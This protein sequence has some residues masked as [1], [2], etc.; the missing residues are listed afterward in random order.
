ME[1]QGF[2]YNRS[3]IDAI[4][5]LREI[6]EKAIEFNKAAFMCFIYLT[7]AFNKVR[8]TEVIKLIQDRKEYQNIVFIIREPNTGNHIRVK[9]K[10][11]Q[12]TLTQC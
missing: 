11:E 8:L 5:I 1:Q 9:A 4:F 10:I 12:D 3:T 7:Q 2:R 6:A